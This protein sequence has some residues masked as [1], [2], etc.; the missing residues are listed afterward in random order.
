MSGKGARKGDKE[1]WKETVRERCENRRAKN[2]ELR[3]WGERGKLGGEGRGKRD[4]CK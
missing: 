4:M 2:K 3:E 1:D